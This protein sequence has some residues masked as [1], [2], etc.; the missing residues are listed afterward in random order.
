MQM[1][2]D[3]KEDHCVVRSRKWWRPFAFQIHLDVIAVANGLQK[4]CVS[5]KIDGIPS[6]S[7][8]RK[9]S[10]RRRIHER[11]LL[12]PIH[13]DLEHGDR[14]SE[15]SS[16]SLEKVTHVPIPQESNGESRHRPVRRREMRGIH[17]VHNRERTEVPTGRPIR[18]VA[19]SVRRIHLE[20]QAPVS[21][22]NSNVATAAILAELDFDP[23][24]SADA[25]RITRIAIITIDA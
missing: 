24:R 18:R 11:Q 22:I 14:S 15:T 1:F 9:P 17:A 4:R 3:V 13:P 8:V 12:P 23:V 5:G 7:N 20:S 2:Q 16:V 10:T 6:R 19:T 21:V 25:E